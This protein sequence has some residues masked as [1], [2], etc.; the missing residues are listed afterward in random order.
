MPDMKLSLRMGRRNSVV[1]GR[2]EVDDDFEPPYF[3]KCAADRAAILD[4]LSS[5]MLF[6]KLVRPFLLIVQNLAHICRRT[7]P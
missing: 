7:R 5:S 4:S 6:A 2:L 3:P 1:S